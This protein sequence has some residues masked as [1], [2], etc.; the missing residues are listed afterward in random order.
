[1]HKPSKY[2]RSVMPDNKCNSA[3]EIH[4]GGRRRESTCI[5][6]MRQRGGGGRGVQ[7]KRLVCGASR[8]R[9]RRGER[10]KLAG[11]SV[12]PPAARCRARRA[13]MASRHR[14]NRRA[15]SAGELAACIDVK[16]KRR[17]ERES[18]E[19]GRGEIKCEKAKAAWAS[20]AFAGG[21]KIVEVAGRNS[22]RAAARAACSWRG[23]KAASSAR[24]G[25]R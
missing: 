13:L 23:G 1:M 9:K 12:R 22:N 17:H 24:R 14:R 15:I 20:A 21:S 18:A 10:G 4:N 11:A 16:S 5:M 25:V 6:A 3:A 7:R 19:R 8:E 2:S